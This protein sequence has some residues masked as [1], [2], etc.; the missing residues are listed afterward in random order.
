MGRMRWATYLW[1]GVRQL[2][3]QGNPSALI[4]SLAL[5]VVL[6][7]ALLGT[8]GWSELFTPAVRNA[9]WIALGVLWLVA[10][11]YTARWEPQAGADQPPAKKGDG[12]EEALAYYLKG[13]WFEAER[14]LALVLRRRP[15][16]L[17]ARM[18]LATLLR[19]TRRWDE[20]L[21]QL[22]WLQKAEGSQKWELE[23]WRERQWLA[24]ARRQS[25]DEAAPAGG[26]EPAENKPGPAENNPDVGQAA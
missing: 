23:M 9:L 16:D 1:P 12:F 10:L 20:A 2:W 19:H 25:D 6:D 3:G 22:D 26:S 11:V 15:Q 17:D 5:A 13:N 24:E 4:L 8:F 18:M 21:R 7:V 14:S